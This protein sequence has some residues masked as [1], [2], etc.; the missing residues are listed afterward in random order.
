MNYY[1]PYNKTI[2]L[3]TRCRKK[4]RVPT[5]RGK[6]IVNCPMCAHRFA[7]NPNSILHT[8]KQV[9]LMLLDAVIQLPSKIKKLPWYF[10]RFRFWFM[11]DRRNKLI[12]AFAVI[13]LVLMI[14]SFIASKNK[15]KKP[16][17]YE[18]DFVEPKYVHYQL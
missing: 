2:I 8:L 4:L 5:D 14:V 10:Q 17:Y 15:A 1:G 7:Y 13:M 9:L 6:I 16:Q 18:P 12:V 11:R 3:C